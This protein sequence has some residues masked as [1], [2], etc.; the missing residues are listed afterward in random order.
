MK[1]WFYVEHPLRDELTKKDLERIQ[2]AIDNENYDNVTTE[3]LDAANDIF[4]DAIAAQ[5]Q[6]HEGVYILQ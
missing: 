4:Y 5:Q 2:D 1:D 3:E 6:T